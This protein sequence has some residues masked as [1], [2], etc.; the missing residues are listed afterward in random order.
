M[1]CTVQYHH[2]TEECKET[3]GRGVCD[4]ITRVSKW[5]HEMV[6]TLLHNLCKRICITTW[7][8]EEALIT[9]QHTW[10]TLSRTVTHKHAAPPLGLV[11]PSSAAT[12]SVLLQA[13]V[14][15]F[16]MA[17]ITWWQTRSCCRVH[18][19]SFNMHDSS[20]M[21][22]KHKNGLKNTFLHGDW[23]KASEHS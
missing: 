12:L 11:L 6:R 2:C 14:P 10:K 18:F 8:T 13:S 4:R 17:T 23:R 22:V 21:K 1:V 9:T 20:A 16:Q 7:H 5:Q 3:V 15:V 19:G